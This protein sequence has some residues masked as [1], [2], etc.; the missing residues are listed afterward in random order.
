[1]EQ[2]F[3]LVIHNMY[4]M[5]KPIKISTILKKYNGAILIRKPFHQKG[6]INSHPKDKKMALRTGM[7]FM[8]PKLLGMYDDTFV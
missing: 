4:I 8:I 7:T 5:K 2:G 3:L 1:M 6:N